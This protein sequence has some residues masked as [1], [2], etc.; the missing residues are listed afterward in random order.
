MFLTGSLLWHA[1]QKDLGLNP[2]NTVGWDCD[3][4]FH[5]FDELNGVGSVSFLWLLLIS[6][7]SVTVEADEPICGAILMNFDMVR[8]MEVGHSF[9]R[10]L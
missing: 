9:T 3:N 6:D 1:R 2:Y 7:R 10:D 5:I 4:A 8:L